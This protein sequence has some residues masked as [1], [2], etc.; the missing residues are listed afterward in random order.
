MI[1]NIVAG[2]TGGFVA[3]TYSQNVLDDSPLGFWL[4][5]ETSGSTA[6]DSTTNNK[7]LTYYNTPTLN[8]S[9]GLTGITKAVTF[10]GT[11]EY[12]EG[13]QDALY[14]VSPSANWSAE[15][16]VKFTATGLGTPYIIYNGNNSTF[17]LTVNNG[18]TGRIQCLSRNSA[19]SGFV[20]LNSDGGWNDGNWHQVFMTSTS[21]G[22]LKL[23]VDSVERASSTAAR[24]TV[25]AN[26]Q[27][28]IGSNVGSQ[29]FNGSAA[30]VSFYNTTLSDSRIST[31]Y[32]SGL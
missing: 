12:A 6:D 21:G 8:V 7:D 24:E 26:R 32:T 1:G 23:Y 18:V 16:W 11:D 10:N 31:H 20:T 17:V 3:K 25:S 29:Y 13:A 28:R 14:D 22:A 5:N 19:G 9:T 2:I 30:A 4:L 15:I 27:V